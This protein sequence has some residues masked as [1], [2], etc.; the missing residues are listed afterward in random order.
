VSIV[1]SS[2]PRCGPYS[3]STSPPPIPPH[4]ALSLLTS[5]PTPP[6]IYGLYLIGRRSQSS[7]TPA[8]ST[9]MSLSS[10]MPR[11]TISTT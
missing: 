11:S 3:H 6:L 5:S 4:L 7:R 2:S 10:G 8:F 1:R 9:S